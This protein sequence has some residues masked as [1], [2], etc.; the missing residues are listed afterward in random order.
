MEKDNKEKRKI[1][2][3]LFFPVIIILLVLLVFVFER[4]MGLSFTQGGVMPRDPK[5]LW[6]IFTMPFIHSGWGHLFNNVTSFFVLGAA[7]F[8][9]YGEIAGK[10]LGFTL[11]LSGLILWV[12]GREAWHISL[13]VEYCA[14][15]YL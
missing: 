7:L 13:S 8:Y 3:A 11:V 9:F 5:S 4:S 1:Y 14:G 15:I 12:I 2:Y 6:H 10:V